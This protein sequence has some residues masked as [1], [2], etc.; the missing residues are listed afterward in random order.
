MNNR[1]REGHAD[2]TGRV[3]PETCVGTKPVDRE[4]GFVTLL[5]IYQ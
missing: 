2:A 4:M 1:K 3:P 5:D